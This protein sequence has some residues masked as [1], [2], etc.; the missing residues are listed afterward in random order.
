MRVKIYFI[1][2]LMFACLSTALAQ[3][4]NGQQPRMN[5]EEMA[6]VLTDRMTTEIKLNDKQKT[7]VSDINL[8]YAKKMMEI[9][10]ENQGNWE[11]IRTKMDESR[12]MKNNEMKAILTAEQYKLYEEFMKKWLEERRKRMGQTN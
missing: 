1:A 11:V 10:Q 3:A 8:K 9:F 4:P 6:K 7:E 5:P 2:T 12:A